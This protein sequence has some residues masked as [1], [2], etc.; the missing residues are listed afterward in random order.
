MGASNEYHDQCTM[1]F[2]RCTSQWRPTSSGHAMGNGV[3]RPAC[4]GL[5]FEEIAETGHLPMDEKP[6]A[7]ADM[8]LDFIDGA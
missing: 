3:A 1:E 6:E 7:L 5:R 8:L 2:L 4:Q